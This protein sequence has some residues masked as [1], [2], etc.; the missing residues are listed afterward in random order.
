MGTIT[1]TF[2]TA[3]KNRVNAVVSDPKMAVTNL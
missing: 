2:I 3:R 1:H